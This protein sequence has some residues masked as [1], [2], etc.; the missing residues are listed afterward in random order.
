MSNEFFAN[1]WGREFTKRIKSKREAVDKAVQNAMEYNVDVRRRTLVI[2]Y[3]RQLK[4]LKEFY[5]KYAVGPTKLNVFNSN[6]C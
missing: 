4:S 1:D 5:A 3:P 2:D 6:P